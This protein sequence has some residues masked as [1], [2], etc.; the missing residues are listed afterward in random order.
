MSAARILLLLLREAPK[1]G[2]RLT[3]ANRFLQLGPTGITDAVRKSQHGARVGLSCTREKGRRNLTILVVG[4][5]VFDKAQGHHGVGNDAHRP[6]RDAGLRG[7]LVQSS[8]PCRQGLEQAH[9]VG[10]EEVL[11][12]HESGHDC[13]E[14][15]GA[16]GGCNHILFGHHETSSFRSGCSSLSRLWLQRKEEGGG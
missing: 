7:Q 1:A 16:D 9:F 8:R 2:L 5:P 6:P 4:I 11:R 15:L 13:Q 3:R 14:G 12:R 10:D